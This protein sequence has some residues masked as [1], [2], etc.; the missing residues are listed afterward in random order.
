MENIPQE[1]IKTD[2]TPGFDFFKAPDIW[3]VRV[4]LRRIAKKW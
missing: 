2:S 4:G 1:W 3:I